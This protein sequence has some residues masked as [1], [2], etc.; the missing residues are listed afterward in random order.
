MKAL[1]V[2]SRKWHEP[3][4]EAYVMSTEVGVRIDLNDFIAALAMYKSYPM[5]GLVLKTLMT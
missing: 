1:V 5:I 3:D 4:I 2:K